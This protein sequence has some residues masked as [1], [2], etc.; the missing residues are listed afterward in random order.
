MTGDEGTAQP[1][2]PQMS[3]AAP[4]PVPVKVPLPRSMRAAR[5]LWI[6]SFVPGASV[7]V[8]AFLSQEAH[9]GRLDE[10]VAELAA[11]QG[12]EAP[13]AAAPIAFWGSIGA[14]A[15]VT[16]IEVILISAMLR[17]RGGVR[18]ALL[19]VL[20]LHLGVVLLADAFLGLGDYGAVFSVLLLGQLLLAAFAVVLSVLPRSSAWFR[21]Q[22]QARFGRRA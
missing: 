16:A 1:P 14:L 15:L 22:Q 21:L 9:L 3:N 11:Q 6:A 4:A 8:L 19:A 18:W 20:P 7:I 10:L 13:D 17:G 12:I 2:R 5:A